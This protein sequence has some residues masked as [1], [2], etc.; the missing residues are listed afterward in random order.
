MKRMDRER[1]NYVFSQLGEV[2]AC[3]VLLAGGLVFVGISTLV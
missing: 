1:E 3:I 2:L